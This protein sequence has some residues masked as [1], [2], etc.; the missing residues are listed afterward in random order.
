LQKLFEVLCYLISTYYTKKK[1]LNKHLL[2]A[3]IGTQKDLQS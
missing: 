1:D 2:L 3:D